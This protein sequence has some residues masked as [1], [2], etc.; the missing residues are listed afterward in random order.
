MNKGLVLLSSITILS[1]LHGQAAAKSEKCNSVS[2][3]TVVNAPKEC[4]WKA[5]T[6]ADKFDADIKSTEGKEAIVQQKFERIP[7]YGTVQTTLKI[8]VKENELLSYELI[9]ADKSLKE[10]SGKWELTPVEQ[11]KTRLKLTSNIEPGLP[12]PRFLI[13]Q[14]IKGKVRTRLHKTQKLAEE[15]YDKQRKSE[16]SSKVAPGGAP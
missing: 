2:D 5:V 16:I 12:I 13:N 9:E 8:T 15:L 11:A 10:M 7:F 6:S 1:A 3:T 4:V 14:F